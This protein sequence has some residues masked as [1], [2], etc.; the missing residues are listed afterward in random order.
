MLSILDIRKTAGFA[1][2]ISNHTGFQGQAPVLPQ[3]RP[4]T[5]HR[6]PSSTEL[7]DHLRERVLT[8]SGTE[9]SVGTMQGDSVELLELLGEGAVGIGLG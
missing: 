5:H 7:I 1:R 2:W 3:V 9:S 6:V 4:Q 8:G